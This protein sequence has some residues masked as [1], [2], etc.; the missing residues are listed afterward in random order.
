MATIGYRAAVADAFGMKFTGLIAYAMWMFIHVLYLV[1]WG[2]RLGT[3]YTWL[4][5]LVFSKNRGHRI[6]TFE[7]A[8]DRLA[9]GLTASGRPAPVT[10][11]L[12]PDNHTV[13]KQPSPHAEGS[14]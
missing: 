8:T 7:Q 12:P 2:N 1:G 5:A 14:R 10:P 4:R 3:L 6:I 11:P 9:E 13:T